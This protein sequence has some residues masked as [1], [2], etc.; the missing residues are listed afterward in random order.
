[1]KIFGKV[2]KND[3]VDIVCDICG[4]STKIEFGDFEYAQFSA[5]WGYGS[6]KAKKESNPSL[7]KR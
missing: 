3:V 2:E 4:V 7:F 6:S 1:M 5:T